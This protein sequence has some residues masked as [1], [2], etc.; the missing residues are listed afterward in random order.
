MQIAH[1]RLLFLM[2]IVFILLGLCTGRGVS[3]AMQDIFGW[4]QELL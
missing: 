3:M 1:V 2:I 4:V